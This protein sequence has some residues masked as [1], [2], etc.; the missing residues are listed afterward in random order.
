[1]T[2]TYGFKNE[3]RG[4]IGADEP[5]HDMWI[6]LTIDTDFLVHDI[7]AVTDAGPYR[8]CPD[9]TPRF[10]AIKGERIV[11]GWHVRTKQLLGGTNGCTHLVEMRG[12][13]GTVASQ[14]LWPFK[15]RDKKEDGSAQPQRRP[16]LIDTCHA[17][18]SDGEIVKR[19]WPSFY[20]GP[21]SGESARTDK[22]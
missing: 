18:A 17:Y 3:W 7:V 5:V 14:T 1:D 13:M 20:T 15:S 21:S 19:L 16:R 4:Q 12:A 2:K 22:A 9:I 10:A 8:V 6:R 11:A